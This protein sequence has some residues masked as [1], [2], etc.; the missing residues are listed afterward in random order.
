MPAASADGI[1]LRAMQAGDLEA[2]HALSLAVHWP[3]R[4]ADW[5]AAFALGGGLVAERDGELVGTTLVWPWGPAH[6]TLGLVIV[7][8]RCQG[9]RIGY[10]L[11][12]AALAQ[13]GEACCVLLHA[14]AEG[15]GLYERLGFERTGEV[16]QHQGTA[17]S[18][19]LVALDEGWRL[20]PSDHNDVSSLIELDAQARGMPREAL[21]TELLGHADTVLLDHEGLARGFGMLR[22]FGRGLIIG[23]VV[24]PDAEGAKALIAHLVGLSAGKFVRI[25]VDFDSGLT[26]WLETLGLLRVDAPTEMVR[27]GPLAKRPEVRL[28]SLATQALG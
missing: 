8:P 28:F 24:A 7:D 1:V 17:G 14:T 3:H 18:A 6:A 25:D 26:E 13:L 12:Q 11:M 2:A 21:I 15:R 23:P 4:L 20:R 16:R 9:R 27:G 22:R 10:R 19:P 5:Q